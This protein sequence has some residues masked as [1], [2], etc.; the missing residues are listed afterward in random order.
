MEISIC[1]HVFLSQLKFTY[2][3]LLIAI[4]NY[5]NNYGVRWVDSDHFIR[6]INVQSLCCTPETIL[7]Q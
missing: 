6:Y 1:R 3:T 2:K 5:N 7:C 4:T